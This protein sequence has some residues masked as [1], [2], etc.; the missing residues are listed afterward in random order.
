MSV[1]LVL[2]VDTLWL[3]FCF[4]CPVECQI[5]FSPYFHLTCE[6]GMRG[7]GVPP[8]LQRADER[9]TSENVCVHGEVKETKPQTNERLSP[10]THSCQ[11]LPGNPSLKTSASALHLQRRVFLSQET[12]ITG[13]LKRDH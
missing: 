9:K 6:I 12:T 4:L 5:I 1:G 8:T 7:Q 11:H 2:W 3:C 13:L 10:Q